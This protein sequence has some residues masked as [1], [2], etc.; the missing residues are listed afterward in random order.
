MASL[1]IVESYHLASVGVRHV[2]AL[3]VAHERPFLLETLRALAEGRLEVP[4]NE[5][6]DLSDAVESAL[7]AEPDV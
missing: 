6:L 7:A 5:P 2:R 3:D 4:P 1:R